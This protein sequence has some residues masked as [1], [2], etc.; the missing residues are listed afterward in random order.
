MSGDNRLIISNETIPSAQMERYGHLNIVQY[1]QMFD[2]ASFHMWEEMGISYENLLTDYGVHTVAGEIKTVFF[3]ELL[4]GDPV[5][6]S[7]NISRLGQ[8]SVTFTLSMEHE[9]TGD[10]HARYEMV[11]VFFDPKSRKSAPMP[12]GLRK[13]LSQYL[14]A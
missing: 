7:G 4:A 2:D 14:L 11:H 6:I 9:R 8:K 12:E 13:I 10:M 1:V 5:I 3:K